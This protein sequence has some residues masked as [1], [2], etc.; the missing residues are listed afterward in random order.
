MGY[1]LDV[2]TEESFRNQQDVV[3][4]ERRQRTE[5]SPFGLVIEALYQNLF[6]K[7]HP[8]YGLI[9]GSH[10]DIQNAQLDDVKKFFK[11]YY[12]PNNASIAIVGDIDKAQ[13]LALVEKYFGTFKRGPD[14]P[15]VQTVTPPIT[16]ERRLTV[17]DRIEL[18]RLYMAWLTPPLFQD[19]NAEAD[20]AAN[21]LGGDKVSR[22]YRSL[23]YEKQIAQDVSVWVDSAAL[24]TP[25]V[26]EATAAAGHTLQEIEKEVNAELEK[27]RSVPATEAELEGAK[28]SVER[29]VLFSLERNGSRDG[30]AD[31]INFYNHYVK[32]PDYLAEDIAR[33]RAATPERIRDFAAKYLTDSSRIVVYGVPGEKVLPPSPPAPATKPTSAGSE[34]LNEDAAWRENPP[35]PGPSPALVIPTPESLKLAN[36][37][38]VILNRRSGPTVAAGIVFRAGSAANATDKA[39]LAGFAL[40]MLD[41]GTTSR[42]AIQFAEDLKRAGAAIEELPA[43]DYSSLV[44]TTTRGNAA[45][46]FNLLAD[47]VLNPAFA[48]AEVERIR[49]TRLG[50]LAQMKE[51]PSQI[52]DRVLTLALVGDNNPYAYPVLGTEPSVKGLSAGD[53]REFWKRHFTPQNTA[54]LVAGDFETDDLEGL[55]QEAFG[56][57]EGSAA[58]EVAEPAVEPP[59]S[60]LVI[61]DAPGSAQTQVRAAVLGP[62]RSRAEYEQLEVM[63]MILGSMFSSR[64]NLNLRE[65]HGYSYGAY[66][67]VRYLRHGGWIAVGSGVRTDVTGPAVGE[68]LKEIQ[69]MGSEP[70]TAEEMASATESLVRTLPSWFETTS[71]TVASLTELYVFDLGLQYYGSLPEKIQKVTPA[72]VQAV[73]RK[74]LDP[75]QVLI[76]AVGDRAKI[77]PGLG[78]LG[79]GKAEVRDPEGKKQE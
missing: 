6:P 13:T 17:T 20:L 60:R 24:S 46:G 75:S 15:P 12:G 57:W 55:L 14:A 48:H 72:E 38:T 35:A 67:W 51:D 18:P 76:V 9:I 78:R 50:N 56:G 37:L 64:I 32:K 77:A 66:S 31:R 68:I 58:A 63:N 10:E 7:G 26:I 62:A 33:Y 65:Q 40:D 43:R 73:T 16:E 11:Q 44:L 22:L 71:G 49:K 69:R 70:V 29:W 39:G 3:R 54:I 36:G 5:N 4:N 45:E 42:S 79:L 53:L 30:I 2:L 23:V 52:A 27:L 61:V 8:Y 1:L 28:Q 25:F 47:A 21:L 59:S 19:G 74:Y 34:S 41:E